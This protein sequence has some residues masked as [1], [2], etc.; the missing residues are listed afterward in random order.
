MKKILVTG[1]LEYIGTRRSG[2]IEQIY[3][4][5]SFVKEELAWEAQETLEQA[6][7]SAWEW[8]KSK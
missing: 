2:D 6:I 4:N 5:S 7:I 1:G 3:Y 8:E